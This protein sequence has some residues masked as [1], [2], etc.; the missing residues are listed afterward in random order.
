ML[1]VAESPALFA[2]C[3][4]CF[5]SGVVLSLLLWTAAFPAA[6]A[7]ASAVEEV[8]VHASEPSIGGVVAASECPDCLVQDLGWSWS[9]VGDSAIAEGKVRNV[10]GRTLHDLK[11]A[12]HYYTDLDTPVARDESEADASVILP[13]G[14]SPWRIATLLKPG[15]EKAD[16]EFLV[17]GGAARSR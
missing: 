11:I 15:M 10:S 13:G 9:I 1:R 4:A 17:Y 5:V 7:V 12:V 8:Q 16:V 14:E 2:G 3:C 6:S